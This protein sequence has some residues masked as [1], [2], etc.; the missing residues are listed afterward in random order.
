MSPMELAQMIGALRRDL[1]ALRS[2]VSDLTARIEMLEN[3]R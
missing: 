3:D 1:Q 2:A